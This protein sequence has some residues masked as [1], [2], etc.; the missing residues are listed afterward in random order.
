MLNNIFFLVACFF[1]F[2]VE[3]GTI[4]VEFNCLNENSSY[5]VY[6]EV[7]AVSYS[8]DGSGEAFIQIK[9]VFRGSIDD[10]RIKLKWSSNRLEQGITS[11]LERYIF[12]L[13]KEQD[14]FK[15]SVRGVSIWDVSFYYE[16]EDES[17]VFAMPL[18]NMPTSLYE[19]DQNINCLLHKDCIKQKIT[20]KTL[21]NFFNKTP[22]IPSVNRSHLCKPPE[23]ATVI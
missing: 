6:G 10:S 1:S 9:E 12:F 3:A 22:R 13:E 20:L 4:R 14:Y 19:N 16:S 17:V 5:I 2:F 23:P 8:D 7:R 11:V 15:S 18:I 21:R